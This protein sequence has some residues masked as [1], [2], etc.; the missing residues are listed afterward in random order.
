MLRP[1][2]FHALSNRRIVR[3]MI[4]SFIRFAKDSRVC[5]L[6]SPAN[7]LKNAKAVSGF[8]AS[9]AMRVASPGR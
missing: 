2:G 6:A 5:D 4:T 9:A 8:P 1:I 7:G 3:S